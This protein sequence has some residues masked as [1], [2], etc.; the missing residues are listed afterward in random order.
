MSAEAELEAPS[1]QAISGLDGQ[2][3][4]SIDGTTVVV[5]CFHSE[6]STLHIESTKSPTLKPA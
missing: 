2:F 3:S 6:I 5:A 1:R 4:T